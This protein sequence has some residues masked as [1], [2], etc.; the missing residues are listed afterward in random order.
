M[1]P[2]PPPRPDARRPRSGPSAGVLIYCHGHA[3]RS[4]RAEAW[5]RPRADLTD[6]KAPGSAGGAWAAMEEPKQREEHHGETMQCSFSL[7][8]KERKNIPPAA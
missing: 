3:H 1:S 5:G 4:A 7:N 2:S 8:K 6:P